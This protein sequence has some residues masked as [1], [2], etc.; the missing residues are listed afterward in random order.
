MKSSSSK[1][2]EWQKS[3][4][5]QWISWAIKSAEQFNALFAR[6]AHCPIRLASDFPSKAG[7]WLCLALFFPC[8]QAGLLS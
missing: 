1:P 8:P 2:K 3:S 4:D 6:T 5:K 7:D